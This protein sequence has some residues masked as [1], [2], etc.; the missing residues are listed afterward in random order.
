M[1]ARHGRYPFRT[2]ATLVLIVS[3]FAV[4]NSVFTNLL[5][6]IVGNWDFGSVLILTLGLLFFAIAFALLFWIADTSGTIG[7]LL[8]ADKDQ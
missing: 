6:K 4:V 3:I 5:Q 2:Y 8:G 7:R 1:P